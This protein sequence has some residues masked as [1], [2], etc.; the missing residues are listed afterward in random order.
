V[1]L[2]LSNRVFYTTVRLQSIKH[3]QRSNLQHHF[4]NNK[5]FDKKKK[6]NLSFNKKSYTILV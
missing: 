2:R 3:L 4:Y 6:E 5:K 1:I